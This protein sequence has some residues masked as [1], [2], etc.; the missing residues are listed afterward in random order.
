MGLGPGDG[1]Q[2][3]LG[4]RGA[5]GYSVERL[6]ESASA[7]GISGS[8]VSHGGVESRLASVRDEQSRAATK[9]VSLEAAA[10]DA[11]LRLIAIATPYGASEMKAADLARLISERKRHLE[12]VRKATV[13]L[14]DYLER[15]PDDGT[16]GAVLYLS[17]RDARNEEIART[18]RDGVGVGRH[19]AMV[20][21]GG[22]A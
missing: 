7:A 16:E 1:T 20:A 12:A 4:S 6:T 10:Q 22:R 3:S 2:F 18:C 19:P 17:P 21:H 11:S 9:I 5:E 13:A 15:A 8:E 14:R